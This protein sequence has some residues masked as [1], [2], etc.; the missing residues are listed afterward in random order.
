M[1]TPVT[2]Q[3][4][5]APWEPRYY[6]WGGFVMSPDTAG[7]WATRLL[8]KEL[9]PI[10]NLHTV[11]KIVIRKIVIRTYRVKS[12]A[13]GGLACRSPIHARYTICEV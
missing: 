11:R 3:Q 13:I 5:I 9:K 10:R 1:S 7:A 4:A 2:T 6:R 8:C 12:H